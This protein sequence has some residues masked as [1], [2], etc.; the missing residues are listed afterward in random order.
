MG[1]GDATVTDAQ[2]R[3]RVFVTMRCPSRTFPIRCSS[4]RMT[5]HARVMPRSL[6]AQQYSTHFLR[7]LAAALHGESI[8]LLRVSPLQSA[9]NRLA[10]HCPPTIN[11]SVCF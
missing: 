11:S 9:L 6:N 8:V 1:T 4:G 10:K 2:T 7:A 5:A 3:K